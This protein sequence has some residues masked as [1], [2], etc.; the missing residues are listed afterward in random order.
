MSWIFLISSGLSGRCSTTFI[1]D[2]LR[3]IASFLLS[4]IIIYNSK[5]KRSS[6]ITD[7]L[8]K[9]GLADRFFDNLEDALISKVWQKKIDFEFVDQRLDMLR[10]QSI[11]YLSEAGL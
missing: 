8:S 2:F 10:K 1:A 4:T 3:G 9:L 7:L 6:R 5:N 11:N